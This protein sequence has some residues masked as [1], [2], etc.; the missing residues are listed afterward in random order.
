MTTRISDLHIAREDALLE[1]LADAV[2]SRTA[3]TG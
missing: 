2:R 3:K 1:R